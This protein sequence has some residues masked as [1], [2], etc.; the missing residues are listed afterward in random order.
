M[1]PAFKDVCRQPDCIEIMNKSCDKVLDCG[2]CCKGF[3]GETSCLGCLEEDCIA[4]F[5]KTAPPA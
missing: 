4:N 2:H 3:K 5:N 1:I